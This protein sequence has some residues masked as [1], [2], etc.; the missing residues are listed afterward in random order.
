MDPFEY[1]T[2]LERKNARILN[3]KTE[4][5]V[6]YKNVVKKYSSLIPNFEKRLNSN[7]IEVL[8][9][10]INNDTLKNDIEVKRYLDY[11]ID[12]LKILNDV[13][14]KAEENM[15]NRKVENAKI[16]PELI[17]V[18]NVLQPEMQHTG[19]GCWS[20]ALSALLKHRG[21]D[22]AQNV[23]RAYRPDATK[24][25]GDNT[26][27]FD[28]PNQISS[29]T[30]MI[31][32]V[33]PNTAVNEASY[34][35]HAVNRMWSK[36]ETNDQVK[37]CAEK[38][39]E[40]L[41][42]ALKEANGPVALLVGN[43]YRTIYGFKEDRS[44]DIVY[45]N[46]PMDS[47]V[48]SKKLHE[49]ANGAITHIPIL[50]DGKEAYS[51]SCTFTVSWLT[52]LKNE[53]GVVQ[54]SPRM[55]NS[56]VTYDKDGKLQSKDSKVNDLGTYVSF[57]TDNDSIIKDVGFNT[58]LPKQLKDIQLKKD[59]EQAKGNVSNANN[60]SAINR[61]SEG[62]AISKTKTE[63]KPEVQRVLTSYPLL[64]EATL[65]DSATQRKH[66]R[67]NNTSQKST[68]G[69]KLDT[70]KQKVKAAKA[71]IKATEEK[72][73]EIKAKTVAKGKA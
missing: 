38:M 40:T 1:L 30:G 41:K 5:L 17:M 26:F 34:S 27:N 20:V 14:N 54:Y 22:L 18:D 4:F 71:K 61:L 31:Q 8:N 32:E 3:R 45:L 60:N 73:A 39:K 15:Q 65:T 36:T 47:T 44:G 7:D 59:K 23:I 42:H 43:H 21:V 29:Y 67:N 57:L 46:D 68:T 11:R 37:K 51:D 49:L 66:L 62:N 19:N 50:K 72:D 55:N 53:K 13:I 16:S 64:V 25:V 28:S 12:K 70:S 56:K 69:K 48:K 63:N 33:L 2:P 9:K 58:F 35:Q 52:D 6:N 24:V 10:L